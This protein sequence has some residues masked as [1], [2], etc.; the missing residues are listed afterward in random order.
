MVT[1]Q[2]ISISWSKA[3]IIF[4]VFTGYFLVLVSFFIPFLSQ[5]L[6]INPALYWFITGYLLFVP[7][8]VCAL[9]LIFD[10]P[11]LKESFDTKAKLILNAGGVFV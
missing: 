6:S 4:L 5:Q 10:I 3:G 2:L 1:K 7:L 9:C 8:F 11:P